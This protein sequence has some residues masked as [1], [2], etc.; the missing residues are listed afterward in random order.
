MTK[1]YLML[2]AVLVLPGCSLLSVDKPVK[3]GK[4]VKQSYSRT[5]DKCME[6]YINLIG[7]DAEKAVKVCQ[8]AYGARK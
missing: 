7:I 4:P 1:L 8:A 6:K 3:T 5:M 2:M